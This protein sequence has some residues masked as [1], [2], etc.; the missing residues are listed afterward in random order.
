MYLQFVSELRFTLQFTK[1][2]FFCFNLHWTGLPLSTPCVFEVTSTLIDVQGV[3]DWELTYS[4]HAEHPGP[5]EYNDAG[6]SSLIALNSTTS[7]PDGSGTM[8]L[9]PN[10]MRLP[11]CSGLAREPTRSIRSSRSQPHSYHFPLKSQT[12]TVLASH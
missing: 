1:Q 4:L 2:L 10:F 6:F 3:T 9:S 12:N 11:S 5:R 8:Y 7:L